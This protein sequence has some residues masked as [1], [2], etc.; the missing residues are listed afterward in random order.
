MH[1]NLILFV[2]CFLLLVLS[3]TA[4]AWEIDGDRV[5]QNDSNC[6]IS[7]EPHTLYS[8][9]WVVITLKTHSYSGN[10]DACLGFNTTV[11][12]PSKPA[13]KN[14]WENTTTYHQ[15]YFYNVTSIEPYDGSVFDYGNNYNTYQRA[16][17]YYRP[18]GWDE[19]TNTTIYELVIANV[20]FDSYEEVGDGDDYMIYWH[21][22]HSEW[23]EWTRV[24]SSRY[25]SV[26]Y[27]FMGFDKWY[28]ATDLTVQAG[29]EYTLRFWVDVPVSLERSSGKY[30]FAVKP[31]TETIG[32]AVAN[33][34]FY[35]LDPWWNTSWQHRKQVT[36]A[37][38]NASGETLVNF[39]AYINVSKEPEMQN[40]YDDVVFVDN[41]N[42]VM[43]F[44]LENYTSDHAIFW[45]NIT[46]LPN[47]GASFW[48]YYGNDGATS[49]EDSESVWDSNTVMVHHFEDLND[50]T[51]YDND[52][53]N[54]GSSYSSTWLLDGEREFDGTDDYVDCGNDD[55]LD[56]TDAITIEMWVKPVLDSEYRGILSKGV[57]NKFV[58]RKEAY[59]K[60]MC[61][62][63]YSDG[64]N[65]GEFEP[66][67]LTADWQHVVITWDSSIDSNNLKG[68]RN[69]VLEEEWTKGVGKE[70]ASSSAA[71][72][73]GRA[74]GEFFNGTI[75]E[76]RISNT[77]RSEDWI[78]ES[79]QLVTNQSVF[80]SFGTVE[81][82]LPS[83]PTNLTSSSGL[84]WD[85][86]KTW[87]NYT[88]EADPNTTALV[89]SY[90]VSLNN[91]WHNGSSQTYHNVTIDFPEWANISVYSYNATYGT[92]SNQSADGKEHA[93]I[94]LATIYRKVDEGVNVSGGNTTMSAMTGLVIGNTLIYGILFIISV[95]FLGYSFVDNK[96]RLYGNVVAAFSSAIMFFTLS[97]WSITGNVLYGEESTVMAKSLSFL[98]VMLGVVAVLY[99]IGM[100][101]EIIAMKAEEEEKALLNGRI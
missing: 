31:S 61:F 87:I 83:P 55:S 29:K 82:V 40:D 44:E 53:T 76:V 7:V 62:F 45:V 1:R 60:L 101:L 92:L 71:F 78:N 33:G 96:N 84:F 86:G 5:W 98:C 18:A 70:L 85:T 14:H 77:A 26:N 93:L 16:I 75:D 74:Y 99:T 39:P 37:H 23:V 10:I 67:Y 97:V 43:A 47:T 3:S 8:S 51:S 11:A 27:D 22:D 57:W 63:K 88:W 17:T 32:E 68:Y 64:S 38:V 9:G 34:H 94:S 4:S 90:N 21:T 24:P 54:H 95:L 89:D 36:V 28:Y 48:M 15:A 56:I 19:E 65:S 13:W 91:V 42:N 49:Q 66:F 30:F 80:V 69:S 46:S 58:F 12:K 20:S 79:Y 41:S 25:H 35:Y 100:I 81:H 72:Q 6:Y 59:N 73:I 50:S 52:G 2:S